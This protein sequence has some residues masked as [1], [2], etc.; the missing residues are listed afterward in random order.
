M[1]W[2][3]GYWLCSTGSECILSSTSQRGANMSSLCDGKLDCRDR[4]DEAWLVCLQV[5]YHHFHE[6]YFT[7]TSRQVYSSDV[8]GLAVL[9]TLLL[10]AIFLFI[11]VI[12][13]QILVIRFYGKSKLLKMHM[14]SVHQT[15]M[16]EELNWILFP[17]SNCTNKK[18]V[19]QKIPNS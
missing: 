13:H 11:Y 9:F 7:A 19:F 5:R 2:C 14:N 15:E 12:K 18:N 1:W 6:W 8:T 4:S 10:V 16:N 3:S 17:L